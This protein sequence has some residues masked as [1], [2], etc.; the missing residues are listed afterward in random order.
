MPIEL[1]KNVPLLVTY[2]DVIHRQ[3]FF[4]DLREATKQSELYKQGLLSGALLVFKIQHLPTDEFFLMA[5]EYWGC[6]RLEKIQK[7]RSFKE[8]VGRIFE[9]YDE[10]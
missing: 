6:S 3:R 2:K 7:P 1:L 9:Y 10:T 8:H 4:S 5:K